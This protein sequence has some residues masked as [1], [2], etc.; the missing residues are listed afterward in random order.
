MTK[1]NRWNLTKAAPLIAKFIK[2][3]VLTQLDGGDPVGGDTVYTLCVYAGDGLV[4]Q[5]LVDRGGASCDGKPC[6][7]SIGKPA[8]DGR[9]Y[10]F[11][12]KAGGADGVNKI[13]FKASDI[14]KSKAIVVGKGGNL[15]PMASA[16][17]ALPDATIQLRASDGACMSLTTD[18]TIKADEDFFKA[19]LLP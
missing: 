10:K 9:G 4:G 15:P 1:A 2:G 17:A 3:P 5:L 13:L 16:L 6:W 8:P 7:K 11:K 14:G 19:K 12:D 18:D